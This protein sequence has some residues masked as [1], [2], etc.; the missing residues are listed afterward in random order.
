[1]QRFASVLVATVLT[2]TA[3]HA[4]V[5]VPGLD[6]NGQCIGD[7]NSDGQVTISEIIT[8]VNNALG[9]CPRLP[10]TLNFQ[11]QVGNQAFAC[12]T[13]Y[14]GIGTGSS[15]FIPSDFRFY[16][17]NVK[18]ITAAGDAVPLDLDQDGIWQYQNVALLDFEDGTGP[19]TGDGNSALN[20]SVHGSAPSGVYTSVQF[21]LGLPFAIDHGNVATAPSPLNFPKLWWSWQQGYRFLKV[22]TGD[23]KFRIHIGSTGCDGPSAIQP[24]TTC[25]HPNV[26]TIT[27]TGFNPEHSVII[28][29]LASL[30]SD[31][32]LDMNQANTTPGCQSDP[33][34]QDCAP[35]FQ[36]L[37]LTFPGGAPTTTQKFFRLASDTA[38]GGHLEVGV[39]SNAASGGTL[40]PHEDFD[41]TQ[42]FP[43]PFNECFG[44][45]GVNCDGG[46]RNFTTVNP[47]F[48]PLADAEPEESSYP[49]AD[50]TAVT[51]VLL[52]IDPGLSFTIY[53][54]PL[55]K[56]GD[57][58]PLGQTPTFHADV[59]TQIVIPGGG[60]PGG[61]FSA[62]FQF[63]TASSQYQNSAPFTVKYTPTN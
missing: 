10:I 22:D 18:L 14:N 62:T 30:M 48:V 7:G 33:D 44:G 17:S 20:T 16:V 37:G 29:D 56:A 6:V 36:D 43:V 49:L 58:V 9:S 8:A 38:A 63:T 24:P 13:I 61:I 53:D 52:S 31:S 35:L 26:A 25:A 1:M 40:V 11:G 54:M 39:A 46:M 3:A 34:D 28:A 19:C 23:D 50:G 45:T 42:P 5:N 60:A 12:G 51:L 21:D 15:Q 57:S 27:L 32:N 4:H 55:A 47:G 41:I 2:A 59:S